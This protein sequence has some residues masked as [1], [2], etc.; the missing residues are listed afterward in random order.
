MPR[1][2]E[3]YIDQTL[4][5]NSYE[6]APPGW[7]HKNILFDTSLSYLKKKDQTSDTVFQKEY[8]QQR[9]LK[10]TINM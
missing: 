8:Q 9:D 5:D 6:L 3:A 10:S 1:I 4:I 7:E 2:S